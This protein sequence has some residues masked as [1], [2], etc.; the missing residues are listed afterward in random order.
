MKRFLVLMCLLFLCFML[1]PV[2]TMAGALPG[3]NLEKITI[4][5]PLIVNITSIDQSQDLDITNPLFIK[6]TEATR[7]SPLQCRRSFHIG[8]IIASETSSKL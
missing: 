3:I 2:S 1:V 4:I 8:K 6:Y 5:K 7:M